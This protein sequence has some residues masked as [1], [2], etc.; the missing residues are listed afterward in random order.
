VVDAEEPGDDVVEVEFLAVPAGYAGG[1]ADGDAVGLIVVFDGTRVC[2][3]QRLF[4]ADDVAVGSDGEDFAEVVDSDVPAA[5]VDESVVVPAELDASQASRRTVSGSS[6]GP[7]S[8]SQTPS[9]MLER[10]VSARTLAS[11]L[12]TIW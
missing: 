4:L 11:A 12:M 7:S 9:A 2:V 1:G 5:F 3:W 6:A 8:S 10:S